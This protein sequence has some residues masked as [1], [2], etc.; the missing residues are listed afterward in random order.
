MKNKISIAVVLLFLLCSC[1]F[2]SEK[3][4][5]VTTNQNMENLNSEKEGSTE[6]SENLMLIEEC[7]N[8]Y[9]D[10][11]TYI[12]NHEYKHL[13][14]KDTVFSPFPDCESVGEFTIRTPDISVNDSIEVVKNWLDQNGFTIDLERDLYAATNQFF[15]EGNED[16]PYPNVMTHINDLDNGNGFFINTNKCH[17]QMGGANIYSMSNGV[18]TAYVKS[19]G[20]S[21]LDAMGVYSE[22]VVDEGNVDDMA[23]RS[24]E[25]LNGSVSIGDAADNVKRY[26][27]N[28]TPFFGPDGIEV[29][30]PYVR[31]FSIGDIYG[32]QFNIRRVYKGCP[33]AYGDY[34]AYREENGEER[35]DFDTK[36]AYTISGNVDAY[37]GFS[38]N[39]VFDPIV[40]L[41]KEI[42]PLSEA[43]E[44]LDDY[45]GNQINIAVKK[46]EFEYSGIEN[47]A[48][49]I[50]T[51]CPCWSFMGRNSADGRTYVFYVDALKGNVFFHSFVESE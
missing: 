33:F 21:G 27:E 31:V 10:T 30:I 3:Q 7:R 16:N 14:M 41:Q 50:I 18:I 37:V 26:F 8:S 34:G 17:I 11:I 1:S 35:V 38:N 48:S 44:I 29:D 19:K 6:C 45:V 46:I 20:A 2:N 51:R 36:Y 25:L 43:V 32:Y 13:K 5:T 28:G 24:Y 9:E 49:G 39:C 40:E 4:R 47:Y 23:E 12:R 42:I 22:N 15:N